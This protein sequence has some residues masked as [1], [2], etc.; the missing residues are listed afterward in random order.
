MKELI[1]GRDINHSHFHFPFK[2]EPDGNTET[3][4]SMK[5]VGRP[6]QGIDN[7]LPWGSLPFK[8]AL[9]RQNIM[10]REN[11]RNPFYDGPLTEPVY[12]RH[13]IEFSLVLHGMGMAKMEHLDP[14][15]LFGRSD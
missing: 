14:A 13:R 4:K 11:I 7:P 15:R 2:F 12:F 10:L 8:R 1:E 5:I 6:I 9:F 3:G